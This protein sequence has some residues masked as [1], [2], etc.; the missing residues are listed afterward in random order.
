MKDMK[1]LGPRL[2]ILDLQILTGA[3]AGLQSLQEDLVRGIELS[4]SGR[5]RGQESGG[6]SLEKA[7]SSCTIRKSGKMMKYV[8]ILRWD[9]IV[10]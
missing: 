2:L 6:F 9:T 5:S 10:E 8:E 7:G 3:M 1:K 4:F